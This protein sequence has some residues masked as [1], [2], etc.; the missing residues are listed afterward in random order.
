[1]KLVTRFLLAILI[2]VAVASCIEESEPYIPPTKA[3]EDA[4]LAVYL[5]T[6]TNRGLDIDTTAM[7]A[8]SHGKLHGFFFGSFTTRMLLESATNF[9]L[10]R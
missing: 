4:L 3:E 9:L 2:G 8:F 10:I 7:G 6:L 5:D 1:M